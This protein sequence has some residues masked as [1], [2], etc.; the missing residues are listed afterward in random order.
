MALAMLVLVVPPWPAARGL[1]RNYWERLLRKVPQSRPGFPSPPWGPALAV[2]GP[3]IFT[4][5]ANDASGS[6]ENSSLLDSMFWMAAPKN[7]RTIEVNR[8]RRRNPQKLIKV[9]NNIDVCPE[10]GHLKQKHVLCAYCYEKVRK[11]TAEIRRQIGK[12]EGG[13]FK[14]P[15]IETTVL[16]TGETPSEQDQGKRIIERDRKRP[17]WFTQN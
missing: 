9:K 10:C 2:Q 6:K 14:A 4:E 16:Y 7:R 11:E 1:L 3:A 15:T 13:P 12:Q 8:C 17:S 5:P